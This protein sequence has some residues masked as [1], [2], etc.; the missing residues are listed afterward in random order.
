MERLLLVQETVIEA[1]KLRAI[2]P[3]GEIEALRIGEGVLLV[4]GLTALIWM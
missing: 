2:G 4:L 1:P 3:D